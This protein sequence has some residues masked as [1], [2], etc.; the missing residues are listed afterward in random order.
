[1]KEAC[2]ERH[3]ISLEIVVRCRS[4]FN[5]LD[6]GGDPER[7]LCQNA[8]VENHGHGAATF[9]TASRSLLSECQDQY[10]RTIKRSGTSKRFC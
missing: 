1:M 10:S 8:K 6:P 5:F 3:P 9:E 2:Y 4:R 7:I